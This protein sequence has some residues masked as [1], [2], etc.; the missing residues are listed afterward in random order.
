MGIDTT[1]EKMKM[2][3]NRN[4]IKEQALILIKDKLRKINMMK[5]QIK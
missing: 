5:V 1:N 4:T 3:K 2:L